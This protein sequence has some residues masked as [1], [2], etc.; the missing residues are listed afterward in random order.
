ME[1]HLF[2]YLAAIFAAGYGSKVLT[3]TLKIPEVTGYVLLGVL[4]GGS[5]VNLL[6]TQVLDIL[7]PLSSIALAL[8]A[9]MIGIELKIDVIRRLGRSII[10]IVTFECIGAFLVVFF[11]LFYVFKTNL[12]TALLLGSVASATAPAAT[13][14]VI[15]QYKAKGV[16]T[17]TILAVV[18][19]DDAFAL[20][21]Y[22]FVESF[23]SSNLLGSSLAIGPMVASALLSVA[24]AL[25]LGAVS[26]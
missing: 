3:T 23:V 10:T 22:V 14:A 15:K 20:I 9:F 12:N 6:S 17:S 2:L 25:G 16:L 1:F 13:V 5:L 4:L 8:I 26:G 7:S 19:I 24:I 11:G 18:G 21:I